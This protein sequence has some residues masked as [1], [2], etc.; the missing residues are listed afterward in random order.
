ME[1]ALRAAVLCLHE[2]NVARERQQQYTLL[3]VVPMLT[4]A[5]F[6]EQVLKQ[7]PDRALWVWWRDNYDRISRTFQQQTANPVTTKIGRFMVTE[8]S[9][10]I[11]GQSRSTI[12]L[13]GALQ[14]GGVL[15]V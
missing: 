10:L 3:D 1:G 11:L 2:A 15:V 6:K 4:S 5:D 7:V 8:A 9:R 14:D 12:D 13:R